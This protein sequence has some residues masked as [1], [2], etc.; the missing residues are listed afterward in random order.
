MLVESLVTNAPTSGGSAMVSVVAARKSCQFMVGAARQRAAPRSQS[1]GAAHVAQCHFIGYR[2]PLNLDQRSEFHQS[3]SG[4][5]MRRHS[6]FRLSVGHKRIR[7][8]G[9]TLRSTGPYT[10]CRHLCQ[11]KR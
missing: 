11:Q 7:Q 10:A 9:L 4:N 6:S 2:G 1:S 8:C 3:R 5:E